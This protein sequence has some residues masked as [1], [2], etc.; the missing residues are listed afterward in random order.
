MRSR[1]PAWQ[2]NGQSLLKI[3]AKSTT[4]H[5]IGL[6]NELTPESHNS[7]N[8]TKWVV[9]PRLRLPFPPTL[10]RGLSASVY[11]RPSFTPPFSLRVSLRANMGHG[12]ILAGLAVPTNLWD[13]RWW[14]DDGT[15]FSPAV[16]LMFGAIF[17]FLVSID[18]PFTARLS[19]C[20]NVLG[21]SLAWI[22]AN[23]V[24]QR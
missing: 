3:H 21:S 24:T 20:L 15:M 8:K 19:F 17:G 13:A 5:H 16:V 18:A 2:P 9:L 22:C 6:R 1:D 7:L 23:G 14:E 12:A 4:S 11:T 10:P